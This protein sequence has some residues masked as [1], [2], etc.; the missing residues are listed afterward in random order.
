MS[1]GPLR[2]LGDPSQEWSM[3]RRM[4][5]QHHSDIQQLLRRIPDVA[6]NELP[7]QTPGERNDDGRQR[8]VEAELHP[9]QDLDAGSTALATVTHGPSLLVGELITVRGDFIGSGCSIAAGS[10]IMAIETEPG[11]WQAILTDDCDNITCA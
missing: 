11:R 8:M 5:S 6:G 9:S 2:P 10:P 7:D 3:L 1:L 4:V